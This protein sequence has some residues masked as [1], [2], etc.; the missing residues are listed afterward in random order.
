MNLTTL[1]R[2]ILQSGLWALSRASQ[3][4]WVNG[5]YGAAVIAGYFLSSEHSMP[6]A[7]QQH[8]IAKVDQCIAHNT[9]WFRPDPLPAANP[10]LSQSLV[11]LLRQHGQALCRSGHGLIFGALCL[12]SLRACPEMLV[13]PVI[14]GL[15]RLL[16]LLLEDDPQRYYGISD[17][18]PYSTMENIPASAG[19]AITD[20]VR[21]AFAQFHTAYPTTTVNGRQ[22]FFTG[23]KIH[24]VTLAHAYRIFL[25]LG[26]PELARAA[27]WQ[28]QRQLALA[29][30]HAPSDL[31]PIPEVTAGNLL[32]LSLWKD[33]MGDPHGLK[34][35]YAAMD[36]LGYLPVPER[37]THERLACKIFAS[38]TEDHS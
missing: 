35:A 5:H 1:P 21:A 16:T 17:Y 7:V 6:Q 29:N 3:Y 4:G 11:V 13:P 22:Y 14:D 25:D 33:P 24:V 12:K 20:M 34:F 26:F 8:L 10:A 15:R 19:H 23:E 2:S 30:A 31:T 37:A 32:D 38:L 36:L 18:R 28:Q 27:Y 9:A